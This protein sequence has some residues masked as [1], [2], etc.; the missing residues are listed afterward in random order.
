MRHGGRASSAK[1]GSLCH[2]TDLALHEQADIASDFAQRADQHTAGTHQRSK[3][4][5]VGMPGSLGA[6]E[7]EFLSKTNRNFQP[8]V[9]QGGQSA[10]GSAELQDQSFAKSSLE[11]AT[12]AAHSSQ[13]ARSFESE[14]DGWT[15]L[16]KSSSQ[17]HG[18]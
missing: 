11:A 1:C 8:L 4:V 16:Q 6:G 12:V 2:F 15:T 13:P 5:S 18:M 9:A 7:P 17:H 3:P 10:T 14:S